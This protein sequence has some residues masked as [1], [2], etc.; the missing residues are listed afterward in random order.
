MKTLLQQSNLAQKGVLIF[1]ALLI[2]F[3]ILFMDWSR[4]VY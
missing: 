4:L 2:A 3:C 1:F